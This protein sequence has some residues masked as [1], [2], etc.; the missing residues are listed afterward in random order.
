MSNIKEEFSQHLAE[1][2]DQVSDFFTYLEKMKNA[3]DDAIS[4]Y[5][6]TKSI[7]PNVLQYLI[8]LRNYIDDVLNKENKQ[9]AISEISQNIQDLIWRCEEKLNEEKMNTLQEGVDQALPTINQYKK[10]E[11]D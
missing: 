2:D 4:E 10:K 7:N 9:T 3:L 11:L 1:I 5:Q 6:I 8:H